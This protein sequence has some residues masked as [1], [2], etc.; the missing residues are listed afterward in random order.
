MIQYTQF[1]IVV[2]RLLKK[3]TVVSVF[4]FLFGIACDV[5]RCGYD[6]LCMRFTNGVQSP[7]PMIL[8]S[9]SSLRCD[10][11]RKRTRITLGLFSFVLF[12]CFVVLLVLLC[13]G[14]LYFA[15]FV[16]ILFRLSFSV[17]VAFFSQQTGQ[18]CVTTRHNN[19]TTQQ[20]I[21]KRTKHKYCKTRRRQTRHNNRNRDTNRK[22]QR[23][24]N[25]RH[26]KR[27]PTDTRATSLTRKQTPYTVQDLTLCLFT[28]CV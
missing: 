25:K 4:F 10:S 22:K 19:K 14:C 17:L 6:S 24:N 7:L 15:V 18:W 11:F 26:R 9:C 27:Q 16:F 3:K 5:C 28:L 23:N 20:K 2:K 13:F 21:T 12:D 1:V 8:A